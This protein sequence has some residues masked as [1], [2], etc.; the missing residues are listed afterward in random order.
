MRLPPWTRPAV[1]ALRTHLLEHPRASHASLPGLELGECWHSSQRQ[2]PPCAVGA[3]DVRGLRGDHAYVAM[4]AACLAAQTALYVRL[5]RSDPGWVRPGR[6]WPGPP[7]GAA[8]A[9]CGARPPLRSR[10]DHNTG[11]RGCWRP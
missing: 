7:A 10:H 9:Y 8:C 5:Y 4:L 1:T 11:A 3:L 2:R 6:P